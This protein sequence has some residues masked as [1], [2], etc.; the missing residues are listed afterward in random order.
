MSIGILSQV[1]WWNIKGETIGAGTPHAIDVIRVQTSK[2]GPW[3]SLD[4]VEMTK[5]LHLHN[6]QFERAKAP[7]KA[8]KEIKK[9][10]EPKSKAKKKVKAK[11]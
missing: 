2:D 8:V 10:L 7:E 6:Q 5:L 9:A 3:Q 11:K 1:K 4:D